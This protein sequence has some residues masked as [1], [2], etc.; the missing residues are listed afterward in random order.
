MG[1]VDV[2]QYVNQ[3]LACLMDGAM[4]CSNSDDLNEK[5]RMS[6]KY[7]FLRLSCKALTQHIQRHIAE[8]AQRLNALAAPI[9]CLPDELLIKI[10]ALIPT[11]HR[12]HPRHLV[13]LGFV[14][15][16]W[17]RV[18]FET[19]SLWA[20]INSH[21]SD[22]ENRA[23]ILK[24]KHCPLRIDYHDRHGG[25]AFI[26]LVGREAYRWQSAKFQ[27]R[28]Y[29]LLHKFVP[30][31]VPLLEELIFDGGRVES[32]T[33]K[34]GFDIDIFSGGADRLRHVDLRYF[35]LPLNSH[36]LSR[37]LTLKM[38][39]SCIWSGT[40]T[41]EI[42]D[43]LRRSPEL[44][45]FELEYSGDDKIRVSG[46]IPLETEAAY[47]PVLTS[48]TLQLK[49]AKAAFSR[50]LSSVRIPACTQFNLRCSNP[51]RNIFSNAT[52][53]LTDLL[54]STIQGLSDISLT[55]SESKL[56]LIGSQDQSNLAVNIDFNHNLPWEDLAWLIRHTSSTVTWPSITAK[57][58]CHEPLPFLPV[59]DL[60]RRMPS[61]VELT[62]VGYSDPYISLLVD[63]TL[64]NGVNDWVLPDLR[65]LS[66]EAYPSNS[67]QLVR[68]LSRVRNG[69]GE[70]DQGDRVRLG[71]PA[72]LK[73]NVHDDG[74]RRK[75]EPFYTA[76]RELRGEDWAGDITDC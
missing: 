25:T 49:H 74:V 53:H 22:G 42:T 52:C 44:R 12:S 31:S 69:E 3:A 36:L 4:C 58:W 48:F 28:S 35:P 16:D 72:K 24:S 18:I 5:Q 76:S 10:I 62:L 59:A 39:G 8:T 56:E 26:D 71:L 27:L 40:S 68:E 66:L 6:Q 38:S 29:N 67:L 51:T 47:L 54:A 43:M 75:R 9:H 37:L 46:G 13:A 73:T 17:N 34:N 50:I 60:L 7:D 33:A 63:P 1:L 70:M 32:W 15:K 65:E 45:T 55:L 2:D 23:V 64:S 14:S 61:I 21:H 41:S 20:Q 11:V 57:I 30:L 19:P